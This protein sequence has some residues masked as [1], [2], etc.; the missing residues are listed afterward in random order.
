MEE[1]QASEEEDR[2][3]AEMRRLGPGTQ[4]M[5]CFQLGLC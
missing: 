1:E 3:Q 4:R 2:V 5:D